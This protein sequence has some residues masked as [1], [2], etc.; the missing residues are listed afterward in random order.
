MI[1]KEKM[2][3]IQSYLLKDILIEINH[4]TEPD[5]PKPFNKN[6]ILLESLLNLEFDLNGYNDELDSFLETIDQLDIY[7]K[8]TQVKK[9][10]EY[11]L[12][13]FYNKL[14]DIKILNS[15]GVIGL[16]FLIPQQSHNHYPK[17]ELFNGYIPKCFNWRQYLLYNIPILNNRYIF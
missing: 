13:Y 3:L 15:G 16:I 11:Y 7:N 6:L 8:I 4:I 14:F 12:D 2:L 9:E 1:Y 10:I 5:Y 17:R